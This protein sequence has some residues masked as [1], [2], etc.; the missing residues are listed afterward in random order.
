[1]STVAL[2]CRKD[3]LF[4]KSAVTTGYTEQKLCFSPI[5]FLH[6]N[7]FQMDQRF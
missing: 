1:M 5:C 2:Y 7:K 6:Q 4:N 3:R